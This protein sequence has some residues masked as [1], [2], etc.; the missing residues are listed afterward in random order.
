MPSTAKKIF[1]DA[2]SLPADARL[3]L[4]DRLL[5][6]LNSPTRAQIDRLWAEEAERRIEEIDDGKVKMIPGKR[7]FADIRKKYPR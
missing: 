2:L 7:V 6:S 5:I 3:D 4:V 1:D